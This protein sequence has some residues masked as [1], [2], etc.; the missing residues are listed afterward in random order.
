MGRAICVCMDNFRR[1][2][3]N[4]RI[5]VVL[6]LTVLAEWS[7]S[8]QMIRDFA[9]SVNLPS[10][11]WIYPFLLDDWYIA[12]VVQFGIILLFCDAPFMNEG[13]AYL[14]SRAGRRAWLFGQMLFIVCL[15][16]LYQAFIALSST[17]MLFPNVEW[18]ANWGKV[19]GTLAQTYGDISSIIT[20]FYTPIQAVLLTLALSWMVTVFFGMLLFALNLF[21]PRAWGSIISCMVVLISIVANNVFTN[22]LHRFAPGSW[23]RLSLISRANAVNQPTFAYIFTTGFILIGLLAL[24]AYLRFLKRPIE[25]LPSI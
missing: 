19:L 14:L 16:F 6:L 24:I 15:S 23:M 9:V 18:N 11:P 17:A 20:T 1:I 5:F 13:T 21:L 2:G 10:A 3:K 4:P 8:A 22:S 7:M 25:T 12:M